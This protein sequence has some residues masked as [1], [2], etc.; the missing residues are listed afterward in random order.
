[1]QDISSEK[2]FD[3]HENKPVAERL[4]ISM[5]SYADPF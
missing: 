2:E 1:M 5:V 3:F 4:F